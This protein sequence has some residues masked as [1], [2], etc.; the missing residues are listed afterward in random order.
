MNTLQEK[1]YAVLNP[2]DILTLQKYKS[3]ELQKNIREKGGSIANLISPYDLEVARKENNKL[4]LPEHISEG[5]LL[6]RTSENTYTIIRDSKNIHEILEQK[7]VVIQNIA[8]LLGCTSFKGANEI[9]WTTD[10]EG[11]GNFDSSS[12]AGIPSEDGNSIPL[13]KTTSAS[14][15]GKLHINDG[16]KVTLNT[17][18]IGEYD[19]ESYEKAKQ[20]A[21]EYNLYD[22][23]NIRTLIDQRN[24]KKKH[25]VTTGRHY[26]IEL[27]SD[28]IGGV[29]LGYQLDVGIA[30]ILDTKLNISAELKAEEHKRYFFEF[31]IDFEKKKV[32][33][34]DTGVTIPPILPKSD[35]ESILQ[36]NDSINKLVQKIEEQK[37]LYDSNLEA[38]TS[39]ISNQIE[40]VK[41]LANN[42]GNETAELTKLLEELR[43]KI[44]TLKQTYD[45]QIQSLSE[46]FSKQVG[47]MLTEFHQRIQD[48]E[49][50]INVK[51]NEIE[52]KYSKQI[53][54]SND[55]TNQLEQQI[56][57][58]HIVLSQLI[59]DAE[60]QFKADLNE[61]EKD[62]ECKLNQVNN[63]IDILDQK[64]EKGQTDILNRLKSGL[65][66]CHQ[67]IQELDALSQKR[68]KTQKIIFYITSAAIGAVAISALVLAITI[69]L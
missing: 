8:N 21:V 28:I 69:R 33:S 62:A 22:D 43:L 42:A 57:S 20:F 41:E 56:Q 4:N 23:I 18:S 10:V 12:S 54:K 9:T 44:E 68:A 39:S 49:N 52:E 5:D 38:L 15:K 35:D 16:G 24:P 66:E 50:H 47:T 1:T 27:S 45:N 26:T 11:K 34:G 37:K 65:E 51:L 61:L 19:E 55:R 32:E 46:D 40:E 7:V 58:E 31:D 53:E 60:A 48:V 13:S 3:H 29:E 6:V 2:D 25:N 67:Q 14:I 30:K 36:L 64:V 17:T 63:Q 59:A